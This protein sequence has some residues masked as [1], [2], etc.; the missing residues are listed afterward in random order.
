MKIKHNSQYCANKSCFGYTPANLS[1]SLFPHCNPSFTPPPPPPTH[2]HTH[3]HTHTKWT[4]CNLPLHP[5]AMFDEILFGLGSLSLSGALKLWRLQSQ[6]A[7]DCACVLRCGCF[8]MYFAT[9]TMDE[10]WLLSVADFSLLSFWKEWR[11]WLAWVC[12]QDKLFD[13]SAGLADP[14][15]SAQ[16]RLKACDLAYVP[17]KNRGRLQSSLRHKTMT[18]FGPLR[19]WTRVRSQGSLKK[20]REQKKKRKRSTTATAVVW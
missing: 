20:M 7:D 1:V 11:G 15:G 18:A 19:A 13:C 17:S 12:R 6:L 5:F 3:T 4:Q 14:V 8:V 2:T 16:N 9:Y 10:T